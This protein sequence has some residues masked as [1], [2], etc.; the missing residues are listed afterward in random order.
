MHILRFL[1]P[2][3]CLVYWRKRS[4]HEREER[5]EPWVSMGQ[6]DV[7]KCLVT[8]LTLVPL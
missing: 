3:L 6:S 1:D 2:V 4:E 8:V 5:V 7:M